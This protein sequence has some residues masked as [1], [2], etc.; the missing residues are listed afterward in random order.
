M[1]YIYLIFYLI[2][3]PAL[4]S[5]PQPAGRVSGPVKKITSFPA[6][7]LA[8]SLTISAFSPGLG[9]QPLY[10]QV[11]SHHRVLPSSRYPTGNFLHSIQARLS[12][13]LSGSFSPRLQPEI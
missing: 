10:L 5:Y 8:S 11:I 3:E 9:F 1:I 7:T 4:V 12:L 6:D 13:L 2:F